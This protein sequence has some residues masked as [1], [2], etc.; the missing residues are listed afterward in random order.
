MARSDEHGLD[1]ILLGQGLQFLNHDTKKSIFNGLLVY[2]IVSIKNT[3]RRKAWCYLTMHGMRV[4]L[5]SFVPPFWHASVLVI[6]IVLVL[7]RESTVFQ[8]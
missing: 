5:S 1:P 4:V 6:V 8:K 7:V 3:R 2:S